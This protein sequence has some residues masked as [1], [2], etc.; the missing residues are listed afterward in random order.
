M[1]YYINLKF[2]F[3]VVRSLCT[4]LRFSDPNAIML[5]YTFKKPKDILWIIIYLYFC[6]INEIPSRNR[7][8]PLSFSLFLMFG[9]FYYLFPFQ[10]SSKKGGLPA[11]VASSYDSNKSKQNKDTIVASRYPVFLIYWC[12]I[13]HF[14]VYFL[15][16]LRTKMRNFQKYYQLGRQLSDL[17]SKIECYFVTFSSNF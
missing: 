1:T 11:M 4:F 10:K 2:K 16:F 9:I 17:R 14:Y 3:L 8:S 6:L 15:G 12:K 7:R 13:S 5:I